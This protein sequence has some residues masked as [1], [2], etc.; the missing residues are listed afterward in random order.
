MKIGPS[1]VLVCNSTGLNLTT[2]FQSATL[3]QQTTSGMVFKHK[4]LPYID[5]TI[6]SLQVNN[7]VFLAI[8]TSI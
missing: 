3:F 7:I 4:F 2:S 6:K 1:A 8:K 5:D